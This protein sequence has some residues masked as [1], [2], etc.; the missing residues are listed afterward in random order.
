MK[1]CYNEYI[2]VIV[3]LPSCHN[4]NKERDERKNNNAQILFHQYLCLNLSY[5]YSRRRHSDLKIHYLSPRKQR[6]Y[7]DKC[8]FFLG[9]ILDYV[10]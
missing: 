5:T 6:G 9:G 2:P 4:E 8:H 7:C 3:T 1:A 10:E